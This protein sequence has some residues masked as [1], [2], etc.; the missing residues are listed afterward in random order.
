MRIGIDAT[1]LLCAE[2]RG[3]GKGLLRLYR[4]IAHLRPEFSFVLFGVSGRPCSDLWQTIPRA[5]VLRFDVPGFRWNT[6]EN[7]GLPWHAW[8]AGCDV[9]HCASSGA[10]RY[11]PVPVLMTVHDLIPLLIDDGQDA[12]GQAWFRR[13]LANGLRA[14]GAVIAVSAQTRDDL[15]KCFPDAIPPVTVVHWGS[16]A[17]PIDTGRPLEGDYLLALGG[18]APRKNIPAVVRVFARVADDHP[19]LRLV[20]LGMG[21]SAARERLFS[22]A[23]ELGVADRLVVPGFVSETDLVNWYRHARCLCYLSLYEGFGLP[24]L[25]AMSCGVPVVASARS[26][27]PE[28]VGDAGVLVD[29]DDAAATAEALNAVLKNELWRCELGARALARAQTFTWRH[30]AEA[31]CELLVEVAGRRRR[32]D[33]SSS[34]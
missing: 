24:I 21:Q 28:V 9:L 15:K 34:T 32:G 23:T 11:S 17:P 6:W 10:P 4:E 2:P 8:R 3:E 33:G 16:D 7:V 1:S 20:V 25:E 18:G 5:R 14:A 19:H 26:S 30:T 31:T 27:I 12:A 22:L 29:P 13:R